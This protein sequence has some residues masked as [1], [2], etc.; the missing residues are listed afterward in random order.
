[1]FHQMISLAGPK[2]EKI[3]TKNLL[4]STHRLTIIRISNTNEFAVEIEANV[5][6]NNK[7]DKFN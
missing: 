6:D 1:M 3:I 4:P 5:Y 2:L 7:R